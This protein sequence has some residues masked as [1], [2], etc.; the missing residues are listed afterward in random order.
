[1]D[2]ELRV[3]L[4][5]PELTRS[6]EELEATL[7]LTQLR[8]LQLA[9][10]ARGADLLPD[11]EVLRNRAVRLLPACRGRQ[12]DQARAVQH[13]HVE[14]E[15]AGVDGQPRCELSVRQGLLGLAEHLQHLQPER[16]PQRLELLGPLDL[17]DVP[18]RVLGP[19]FAHPA[20][21]LDAAGLSR[22]ASTRTGARRR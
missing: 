20:P 15:M 18:R 10:E 3:Q 6:R 13:A 19:R 2:L 17:E 8:G 11:V 22:K 5:A 9:R 12:L 14:V 7:Q 16:V 4:R 1:L 21:S